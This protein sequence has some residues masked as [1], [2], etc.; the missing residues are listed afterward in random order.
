MGWS[1]AG[2]TLPLSVM[3]QPLEQVSGLVWIGNFDFAGYGAIAGAITVY[4]LDL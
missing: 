4:C 1:G 3:E 2:L